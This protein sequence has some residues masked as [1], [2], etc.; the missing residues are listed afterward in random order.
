[1]N[2]GN[3]HTCILRSRGAGN[4]LYGD[5]VRIDMPA[6]PSA[7]DTIRTLRHVV[8]GAAAREVSSAVSG[9][10]SYVV[11]ELTFVSI[12]ALLS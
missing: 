6:S 12:I 11:A 7:R 1:M 3:S 10:R 4:E 5:G 9:I 8:E 2:R